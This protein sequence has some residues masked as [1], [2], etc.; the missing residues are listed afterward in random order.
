MSILSLTPPPLLPPISFS[1]FKLNLPSAAS[2]CI[3]VGPFSN[4]WLVMAFFFKNKN[5]IRNFK[6]SLKV[7]RI[8][9][10]RRKNAQE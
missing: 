2:M 3:D 4:G 10:R 6:I 5:K 7:N 9:Q 1:I 8:S